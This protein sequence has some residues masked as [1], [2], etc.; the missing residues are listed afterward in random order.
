MEKSKNLFKDKFKANFK[1]YIKVLRNK[2]DFE[3]AEMTKL[4]EIKTN[5][6]AKIKQEENK[7]NKIKEEK[8]DKYGD[9]KNFIHCV[10]NQIYSILI[11]T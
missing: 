3:R 4:L 2:M 10:K 7:I 5:L 1:K 6:E 11:I 8:L 9:F